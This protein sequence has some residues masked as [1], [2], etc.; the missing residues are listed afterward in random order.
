MPWT[1][2]EGQTRANMIVNE[3]ERDAEEYNLWRPD[4]ALTRF[5][6]FDLIA[7]AIDEALAEVPAHAREALD[8][9]YAA[10]R[11]ARQH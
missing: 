10:L 1:P 7:K 2:T 8:K 5:R 4:S 6:L 9:A 11:P 3:F